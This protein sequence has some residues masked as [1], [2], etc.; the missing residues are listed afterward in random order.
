MELF[1]GLRTFGFSAIALRLLSAVLCGAMVGVDREM[2]N[3]KAGLK[4][5]VLVSLGAALCMIVSECVIVGREEITTDATRIAANVIT[6]VGFLC[7]ASLVTR[8]NGSKHGLTTAAGLWT[9]AVIG[10]SCGCGWVEVGLLASVIVLLVFAL[11]GRVDAYITKISR[12]FDLY[13]EVDGFD[14]V[15]HLLTELSAHRVQ[16]SDLD[17]S[18][19]STGTAIVR[20]VC[21]TEH[22]KEKQQVADDLRALDYVRLL[23]LI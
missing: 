5:H 11:L 13:A 1:E 21:V 6:G 16:F 15:P 19:S 20:L 14:Q 4:T 10:L 8:K 9:T 3:K 18:K 7:A 12:G 2:R 23:E 22:L 17:V